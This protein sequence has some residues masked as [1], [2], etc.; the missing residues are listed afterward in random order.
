MPKLN[1][2]QIADRLNL[3][4][5]TVSRCFTNHPKIN[6]E[7]RAAV[8]QLA[9]ELGYSYSVQ[10]NAQ[11]K[12]DAQRNTIAVLVGIE[13]TNRGARETANEI[14]K[15]I[16]EKAASEGFAIEIHFV[17]PSNFL[18]AARSRRIIKSVSCV[19][20]KG[21]IL[22]YNFKEAAVS[23]IMA[24][25][26]TVSAL[27]DY[28]NVDVDCISQDQSRGITRIMQHLY[29]LGHRKVG[30]MSWKYPVHTPWVE[31]RLGAYFE[32]VYRLGLDLD[33]KLVLN[34]KP[35][36]SIPLDQLVDQVAHLVRNDGVTAWVCAADHQAYHLIDGL[37]SHGISVPKE[38]SVTGYDGVSPPEGA[39]Q[40]TTIRMPFRDIGIS[41]I[42][43]LT[44]KMQHPIA[45]RRSLQVSGELMIGSTSSAPLPVPLS[46]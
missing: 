31:R 20:W 3:S 22:V 6:P 21:V 36:E 18:P 9:A 39:D 29:D 45:M 24:K 41:C 23:N 32:N 34:L 35:E 5:T 2:K 19:N 16:S 4:T 33:T 40:V 42:S 44:R 26:P 43:S 17:D 46:L 28:D 15:G 13:K 14:I 1:Q 7:T 27:E 11:N 37:N 10:R 30:F 38:C 8:F 12:D 25:F